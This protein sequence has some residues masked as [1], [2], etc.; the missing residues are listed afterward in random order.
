MSIN[1]SMKEKL[2]KLWDII[3]EGFS[4]MGNFWWIHW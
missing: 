1:N 4:E 3:V 2:K